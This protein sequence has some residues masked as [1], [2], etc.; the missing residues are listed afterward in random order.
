MDLRQSPAQ[1]GQALNSLEVTSI[2]PSKV[3]Q[4]EIG[5]KKNFFHG[6][7]A[8]NATAYQITNKDNYQSF[9]YT[10]ANGA[11]QTPN[12]AINLKTY[13]GT[14]RSRGAELDITGNPTRQISL[15]GGVSYNHTAYIDT[16][17]DGFIENQRLARTPSTTANLSAFYAFNELA[18]GLKIGATV[19]YIGGRLA[20][21]NDTKQ[22]LI[23]RSNVTRLMDLPDYATLALSAAYNWKNFSLQAKVNNVTGTRAYVVH[24]NYSVNPLAPR[25]FYIT[26]TYKL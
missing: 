12:N 25:N 14:V 3:D 13:A 18:K 5:I 23:R 1:V 2:R 19:Y 9:W 7:L 6:A 10:D 15:I 20:G 16:P 21:W 11:V 8:V 24:E 17:A 4:F 22:T 26:L